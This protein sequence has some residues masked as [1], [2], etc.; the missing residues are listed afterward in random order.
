MA[1][2][3]TR[4]TKKEKEEFGEL[5]NYVRHNVMGYTDEFALPSWMVMR[6]KGM[7]HGKY[8]ENKSTRDMGSYSFPVIL[9]T[10]KSCAPAIRYAI[11]NKQFD[12][13]KGKFNYIMKIVESNLNDV[14][15]RLARA[16]KIERESQSAEAP[17]ETNYVDMFKS[18]EHKVNKKLEELW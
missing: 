11:E 4:L 3:R 2:I 7:R 16:Q 18:K 1:D 6:L 17:V 13:E 14:A 5:Y 10:F 9:Y 8:Y 15:L 12:T